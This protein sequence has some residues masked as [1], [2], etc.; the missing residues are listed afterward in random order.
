MTEA[1]AGLGL[2]GVGGL[3]CYLLCWVVRW[4][5]PKVGLIDSPGGRKAHKAP[6]PLGGGV[7][8]WGSV[9]LVLGLGSA[10]VA[11]NLP[12]PRSVADYASGSLLRV[13]Q[14]WMI[15]GL[16]TGMML[17]GLAD[18]RFRIDWKPRLA[19][20]VLA[21]VGLIAAG[22]QITLFGPFG[23]APVRWAVT[24]LWVVGLTNSFNFLD[25]MD[26]LS[27]GVGLI[28]ALLFVGAQIAVGALFV[29]AVLLV[30]AGALAGFLVHNSAPAK[31]FMGDAGSNFLGFLLGALTVVGTFTRDNPDSDFS[32]FGALAPLLVMAVPLYDTVSVI[33]IRIRE[34]RSP[35]Q[36]D[37]SHF[38]HRLVER[39][40]TP[41]WAVR[42]IYLVTLAG[43]LGA[44]LLHRLDGWGA[45][46]V[47]SQTLCVLGVV[48]ILELSRPKRSGDP[49]D[50]P[51]P[52]RS[53]PTG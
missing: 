22:A 39:G 23:W 8:I 11:W 48:A 46:V 1:L 52:A 10:W 27:A 18:D 17:V 5:A 30:L 49:T 2:F 42:T 4:A 32:P 7:A 43:G 16:A 40:L 47:A 36:A 13:G 6:T 34:G 12:V 25:N 29:P 33:I 53:T 31:L 45:S 37:R 50:S 44:L 3:L 19:L 28:V 20:Q 51:D 26:G 9:V 41:P 38:S 24:L 14:L 35:F 21:A 15:V